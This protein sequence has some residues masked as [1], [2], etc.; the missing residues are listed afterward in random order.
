[1]PSKSEFTQEYKDLIKYQIMNKPDEEEIRFFCGD[2]EIDK[3][4]INSL[5]EQHKEVSIV[6]TQNISNVMDDTPINWM[7]ELNHKNWNTMINDI[8][9][10][11][12][13][14]GL[15]IRIDLSGWNGHESELVNDLLYFY[16]NL[17]LYRNNNIELA[18]YEP[19][20]FSTYNTVIAFMMKEMGNF[21][22]WG[23]IGWIPEVPEAYGI[24]TKVIR[25]NPHCYHMG[26]LHPDGSI[27]F[28]QLHDK[29]EICKWNEINTAKHRKTIFMTAKE[30]G[31]DSC[32]RDIDSERV[33]KE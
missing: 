32:K 4:F 16:D 33:I 23:Y 20:E 11:D 25:C 22:F 28:C 29:T 30:L 24:D 5:A 17:G 8:G 12:Y 15:N 13:Y 9:A 1:M 27:K 31:K 26:M 10:I 3:D 6:E 7:L 2:R 21:C 19:V 18:M 14:Q